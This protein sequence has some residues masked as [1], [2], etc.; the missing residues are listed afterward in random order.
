MKI[1]E[2]D[3]DIVVYLTIT[4][5]VMESTWLLWYDVNDD[6]TWRHPVR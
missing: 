1:G 6:V 5:P 3:Q 4:F 2:I